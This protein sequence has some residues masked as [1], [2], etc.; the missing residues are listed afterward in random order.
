[1]GFSNIIAT[2]IMVIV[3]IVA[4]YLILATLNNAVN[5]ATASQA[6]AR[7]IK[8]EQL[9]TSLALSD[10]ESTP[11]ESMPVESTAVYLDFNVTNDGRSTIGDI[12]CMDV[13][14]KSIEGGRVTGCLWLPYSDSPATDTD[15]WYAM[16]QEKSSPGSETSLGPED[17]M[18]VRCIFNS[19]T[20]PGMGEIAVAAPGGTMATLLYNVP[21]S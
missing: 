4:G 6:T 17:V 12:S 7:D 9:R 5:V 20:V 1:M 18:R 21:V 11:V 14:V 19:S 15:H 10:P 8:E 3:L 16:Y 2:G 13:I